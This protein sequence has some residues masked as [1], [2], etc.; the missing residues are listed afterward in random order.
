MLVCWSQREMSYWFKFYQFQSQEMKKIGKSRHPRCFQSLTADKLPVTY[1]GNKKS[2]MTTLIMDYWLRNL[3]RKMK[4]KKRN[5]LVFLDNAPSH[6][7]LKLSN[8]HIQFFP[9]NTTSFCQPMDQGIIQTLK[10]KYRK[11]QLQYVVVAMDKNS[12]KTGPQILK[13]ITLLQ[14]IN[15]IHRAWNETDP[16]T[17]QKCFKL[18][19]FCES[20]SNEPS[21][22]SSASD[23]SGF[24]FL[25]VDELPLSLVKMAKEL[26]DCEIKDLVDIDTT[27][28]TDM[29]V[30]DQ[31]ATELLDHDQDND[32]NDDDDEQ[33]SDT[34]VPT[35]CMNDA[36]DCL[37]KVREFALQIGNESMF[38]CVNDF[39][40]L[41]ID[42]RVAKTS[43][44][45]TIDHFFQKKTVTE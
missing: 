10:L 42:M 34:V 13:E 18:A 44:Q 31:N 19:G 45:T 17:I 30:W 4:K 14:A 3:D 24:N 6:P 39:D 22:S 9:P 32:C 28:D 12:V 41:L 25:D 20:E 5:I 27:C 1:Y 11:R 23:T 16:S 35:F 33:F 36:M 38:K 2:W 26:F 7:D 21:E 15:W 37:S 29:S 8:V 40:E 43:K